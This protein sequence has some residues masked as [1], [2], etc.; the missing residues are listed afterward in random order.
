MVKRRRNKREESPHAVSVARG[1]T[2]KVTPNQPP[3]RNVR[4]LAVSTG[5][6]ILWL[7]VL[8]WL[9]FQANK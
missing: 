2:S 4:L 9:T 3:R 7:V 1:D 6:L 8:T 5:L